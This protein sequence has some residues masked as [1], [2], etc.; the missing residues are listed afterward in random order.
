MYAVQFSTDGALLVATTCC[1]SD[2]YLLIFKSSDGSLL[3]AAIYPYSEGVYDLSTR[4]LVMTGDDIN[5]D[6][7]IWLNVKQGTYFSA[8]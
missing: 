2:Q 4:N 8:S 1:V 7:N 6:Y 3:R 5:G